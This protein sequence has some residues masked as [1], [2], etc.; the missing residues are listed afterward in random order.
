VSRPDIDQ[1]LKWPPDVQFGMVQ[2]APRLGILWGPSCFNAAHS[3]KSCACHETATW[4]DA[5]FVEAFNNLAVALCRLGRLESAEA[6]YR[7]ALRLVPDSTE[8]LLN[9]APCLAN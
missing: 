5:D 3:K 7:Q 2:T 6:C 4:I 8:I 9:L 1:P